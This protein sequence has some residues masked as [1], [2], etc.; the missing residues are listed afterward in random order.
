MDT[1][2]QDFRYALA[3]LH[4]SR[5]GKDPPSPEPESI[6]S[7]AFR[8]PELGHSVEYPTSNQYFHSLY[9]AEGLGFS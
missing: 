1:Y 8:H 5:K 7:V 2:W 6:Y 3:L 4:G 9:A